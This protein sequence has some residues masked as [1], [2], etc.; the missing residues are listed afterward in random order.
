MPRFLEQSQDTLFLSRSKATSA[1]WKFLGAV[2]TCG[3]TDG[4]TWNSRPKAG[5]GERPRLTS[6]GRAQSCPCSVTQGTGL[7]SGA[8]A[9]FSGKREFS[10]SITI[11]QVFLQRLVEPR[12]VPGTRQRRPC[13]PREVDTEMAFVWA[14]MR[15][16]KGTVQIRGPGF[17]GSL[18]QL[19]QIVQQNC[20]AHKQQSTGKRGPPARP[21]H[22]RG[23]GSR[24][25]EEKGW[26]GLCKDWTVWAMFPREPKGCPPTL[27]GPG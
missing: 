21:S 3:D 13:P 4:R 15:A 18:G 2:R 20:L 10:R 16:V 7:C 25:Q 12:A 5:Q 19:N 22:S 11:C 17:L 9:P 23:R 8:S 6:T 27:P 1:N 26:G 14:A 24:S